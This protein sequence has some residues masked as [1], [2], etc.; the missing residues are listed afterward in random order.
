MPLSDLQWASLVAFYQ[1]TRTNPTPSLM[2]WAER[3]G[4]A[5]GTAVLHRDA[6]VDVGYLE[7]TPGRQ[8][9]M[10]LTGRGRAAAKR[11]MKR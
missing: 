9:S 8:K 10:R 11:R 3:A 1:L 6:L 4:I 5:F 2:E 7:H